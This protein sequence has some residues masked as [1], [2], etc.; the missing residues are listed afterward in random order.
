MFYH[1]TLDRVK[2]VQNF[3]I[4]TLLFGANVSFAATP[5]CVSE[6]NYVE[7]ELAWKLILEAELPGIQN[8]ELG[9]GSI[10]RSS[11][12][13]IEET[14]RKISSDY[15]VIALQ[16][17]ESL[18][19]LHS[20][21]ALNEERVF[22]LLGI[23]E[24][25]QRNEHNRSIVQ[26][27]LASLREAGVKKVPE[28]LADHLVAWSKI[29]RNYFKGKNRASVV[30][31]EMFRKVLKGAS[32][33]IQNSIEWRS[34]IYSACLSDLL[35]RSHPLLHLFGYKYPWKKELRPKEVQLLKE[36]S[37]FATESEEST[38]DYIKALWF[39]SDKSYL[40]F[41]SE[42]FDAIRLIHSDRKLIPGHHF[43][44]YKESLYLRNLRNL[45]SEL[46]VL[47]VS[48]PKD[49]EE[50]KLLFRKILMSVP[51][52]EE[53]KG[54]LRHYDLWTKVGELLGI[55]TFDREKFLSIVKRASEIQINDIY[56]APSI[57]QEN[58]IYLRSAYA[59]AWSVEDPWIDQFLADF[60]YLMIKNNQNLQ[61]VQSNGHLTNQMAPPQA[62]EL[63]QQLLTFPK[64]KR[65]ST[66]KATPVVC[67]NRLAF[68][69]TTLEGEK[70][71]TPYLEMLQTDPNLLLIYDPFEKR[72][73]GSY[74]EVDRN[75]GIAVYSKIGPWRRLHAITLLDLE[76]VDTFYHEVGHWNVRK[77]VRQGRVTNFLIDNSRPLEMAKDSRLPEATKIKK[78]DAYAEDLALDELL[79]H[80]QNVFRALIRL[81]RALAD[82]SETVENI[83]FYEKALQARLDMFQHVLRYAEIGFRK[84][85]LI[86][87]IV[88]NIQEVLKPIQINPIKIDLL[89]REVLDLE[90][91]EDALTHITAIF[92]YYAFLSPNDILLEKYYPEKDHP[93]L[94][95]RKEYARKHLN[96]QRP[97]DYRPSQRPLFKW[98]N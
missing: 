15:P 7:R 31:L 10:I 84:S 17:A 78:D 8:D 88:N 52:N 33:Q 74:F 2:G 95:A 26:G 24:R 77:R 29:S 19:S 91:L 43:L 71:T 37:E 45:F 34:A 70:Y 41:H 46:I 80:K 63:I 62:I 73:A 48:P 61:R 25:S 97:K 68:M 3:L 49:P 92:Q 12:K 32:Y 98:F 90:N 75:E 96:H 9:F 82:E 35:W 66:D 85:V 23:V 89:D 11:L 4:F 28:K 13:R 42:I 6:T 47:H 54:W 87:N 86:T 76:D 94:P 22:F 65:P 58:D 40:A 30:A 36:Y 39:F 38:D 53:E 51:W 1:A 93:Y 59:Q 79:F 83:E 18:T 21:N 5:S 72:N 57:Y 50:K 56:G 64:E 14:A 67:F 27:L 16:F 20:I 69:M 44:N 55:E 81:D 60:R